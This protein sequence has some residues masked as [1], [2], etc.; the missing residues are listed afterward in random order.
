MVRIFYAYWDCTNGKRHIWLGLHVFNS[1][2]SLMTVKQINRKYFDI[3]FWPIDIGNLFDL[4]T[5]AHE[6][7]VL[8]MLNI[9]REEDKIVS[10][11]LPSHWIF[12]QHF[13]LHKRLIEQFLRESDFCTALIYAY[14]NLIKYLA[15]QKEI[16]LNNFYQQNMFFNSKYVRSEKKNWKQIQRRQVNQSIQQSNNIYST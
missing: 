3:R 8:Y 6:R 16:K 1:S 11:L 10:S 5:G 14:L 12:L 13:P 15:K 7:F 2:K 4:F 9:Q